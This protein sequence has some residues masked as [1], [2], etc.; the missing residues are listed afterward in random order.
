MAGICDEPL[1]SGGEELSMLICRNE[2]KTLVNRDF[3][4]RNLCC[5][6]KIALVFLKTQL[7]VAEHALPCIKNAITQLGTSGW[8]LW[9]NSELEGKL[10]V[11]L[12]PVFAGQ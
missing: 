1:S 6:R 12:G 7:A 10:M 8:W 5:S 3:S 4:L 2:K 9:I 11:A